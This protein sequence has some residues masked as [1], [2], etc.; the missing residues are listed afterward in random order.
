MAMESVQS[1]AERSCGSIPSCF[2]RPECERPG[3]AH[4]AFFQ[5]SFPVIDISGLGEG[6]E[7]ERAEIVRGI[8]AACKDWGF[9]HVTNHGVPLQLMDGMRRAAEIFFERPMCE[10]LQFSTPPGE[11][12]AEG[13]ANRM[14]TR[15]DQVLD[16]RDYLNHH[17]LPIWRRNSSNWPHEQSYRQ[18]IEDYSAQ[19][20]A[21]S[22]Q[23]L[24]AIS[25]SLGLGSKFI[26]DAIGEPFQNIVMN[27]YPPCPQ[28]DLTL[29]LQ[30][31]SDFGAITL[32]MEDHVGGLQVRKNGRWFAVKPVPGAFIANLG[33][34]VEVLSNGRYKSVEHRVVVNSTKKRMAIA[35][36]YDP[37]KN[38]RISP[39]PELIDEQNP[40]LYGEVLFRDNVSDFYSKGPEGKRNLDSIAIIRQ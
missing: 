16:W 4:D 7:R 13:Y 31:H 17:A 27:Y 23:L 24:A 22:R 38:T 10:K 12:A 37:S 9:F 18:M 30:S 15:D 20:L 5:E 8:G 26:E 28:P 6:S 36:F 1:I 21:L 25:E 3:L 33:D 40:R 35:A 11:M 2:V 19:V 39:A 34:Q 29:G 32:L 14:L